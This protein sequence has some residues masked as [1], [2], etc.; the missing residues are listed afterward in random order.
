MAA[1]TSD[2][3]QE[4]LRDFGRRLRALRE[5]AGISQEELAFRSRLH[6]TYVSGVERGRRNISLVNIHRLARALDSSPASLFDT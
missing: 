3:E 5:Q 4:L 6:R 2:A 1:Q